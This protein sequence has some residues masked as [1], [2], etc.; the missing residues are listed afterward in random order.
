MGVAGA[1]ALL[2]YW[3]RVDNEQLA[4]CSPACSQTSVD[5]VHRLYIGADVAFGVGGPP[6]SRRQLGRTRIGARER[7]RRSSDAAFRVDVRPTGSGAV[8]GLGG[9]F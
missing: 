8:A 6:R 4:V 9:T 2:T 7:A 3:G 1:G 5:H